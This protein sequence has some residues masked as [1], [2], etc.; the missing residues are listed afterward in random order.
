VK[1]E[2]KDIAK[3]QSGFY[4]RTNGNWDISYLQA[5]NFDEFGELKKILNPEIKSENIKKKQLL[6]KW[7][8][9]FSAKWTRNFATVYKKEYGKCIASSTFFVISIN[10]KNIIPEYLAIILNE[11]QTQSYFKNNLSWWYIQSVP[12][13]V[14]AEFPL[15]IVSLKKQ[16]KIIALHTSHRKQIKIYE[17]LKHQKELLINKVILSS[18]TKL[19][20]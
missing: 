11:S 14:L 10:D 2:L 4:I 12:K 13:S 20:D 6:K 9:L 15:Y 16:K 18:Q 3:I 7:D 17:N 8:I 1:R 19:N 5:K